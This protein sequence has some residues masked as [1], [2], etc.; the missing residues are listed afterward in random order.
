MP[1]K[2]EIE[3]RFLIGSFLMCTNISYNIAQDRFRK[4]DICQG[5]IPDKRGTRLRF[6]V[7]GKMERCFRAWKNGKGAERE[8]DEVEISRRYLIRKWKEVEW[9]L[10]KTRY[11][12]KLQ[13]VKQTFELNHFEYLIN[14]VRQNFWLIEVPFESIEECQAF[15]PPDLFGDEVTDDERYNSHNLAHHGF[16]KEDV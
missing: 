9:S 12:I 2:K 7:E 13:N 1:K 4:V 11:F 14:G 10:E 8:E 3:R 5:Y 15:I 16:P 6:E